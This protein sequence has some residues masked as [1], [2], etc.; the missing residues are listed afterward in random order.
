MKYNLIRIFKLDSRFQQK[1]LLNRTTQL[2]LHS[3]SLITWTSERELK[4]EEKEEAEVS[5]EIEKLRKDIDEIRRQRPIKVLT[6][7]FEFL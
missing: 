3:W 7:N 4:E 2:V 5:E 1:S 6:F